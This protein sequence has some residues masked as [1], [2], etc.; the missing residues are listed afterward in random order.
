MGEV[1]AAGLLGAIALG[2]L[3]GSVASALRRKRRPLAETGP[4]WIRF[5]AVQMAAADPRSR[6]WRRR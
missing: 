1:L 6:Q 4:A 5:A 2:S 3:V